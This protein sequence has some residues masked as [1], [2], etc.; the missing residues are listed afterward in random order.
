MLELNNRR[1]ERAPRRPIL[2]MRPP[3]QRPALRDATRSCVA[4]CSAETSRR[5]T[6]LDPSGSP[7][8]GV[9]RINILW[10]NPPVCGGVREGTGC[11]APDRPKG[12]PRRRGVVWSAWSVNVK[13]PS[14]FTPQ[15]DELPT[16]QTPCAQ[17][18]TGC[19]P[20]ASTATS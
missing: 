20:I 11:E 12:R 14:T 5:C 4:T 7:A 1:D 19:A 6:S 10:K 15:M 17:L 13:T 9:K 16:L 8:F 3:L 18:K 2:W